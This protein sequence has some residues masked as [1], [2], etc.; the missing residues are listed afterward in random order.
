MT[1]VL[2]RD[3]ESVHLGDLLVLNNTWG[4]RELVS[5]VDYVQTATVGADLSDGVRFEWDWPAAEPTR[6]LAYPGLI[7]GRS[8][9]REGPAHDAVPVPLDA[10]M[11]GLTVELE[12]AREGRGFNLALDLWLTTD[13]EGGAAAIRHEVMVWLFRG[14][15]RPAGERVGEV[16]L[17]GADWELWIKDGPHGGGWGYAALVAEAETLSGRLDLGAMLAEID[18]RTP[19]GEGLWLSTVEIGAEIT[20]GAGAWTATRFEVSVAAVEGGEGADALTGGPGA[21]VLRGLGGDDRLEGGAGPDR[22]EGGWGAD[23]L[24]GGPGVDRLSGGAGDDL[25][26]GHDGA[27]LV[28]GGVGADRLYAGG[29]A[30]RLEGGAD[31]DSLH[32]GAKGDRLEGDRGDDLLVGDR[33][34]DALYGG[35]GDDG[36]YGGAG[37]DRLSG[38]PGTNRLSGAEGADVFVLSPEGLARI[39]DFEPGVDRLELR[40]LETG[41]EGVIWRATREGPALEVQGEVRAV[42]LGLDAA[43][44][45]MADMVF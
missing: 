17:D 9:W 2:R 41:P 12:A 5:G 27:D 25:L 8:P 37:D 7:A 26:R 36:L 39:A 24:I 29:G 1:R 21:D 13:P 40:R 31:A 6:V 30:D 32:G 45:E 44:A 43:E 28:S 14:D 15:G 34:P 19:F 10:A 4:R 35:P 3:G 18:A 22:L 38:G 20:G 42:L 11:Q 33:G 23:V 16:T